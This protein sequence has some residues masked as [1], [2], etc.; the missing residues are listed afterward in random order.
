MKTYGKNFNWVWSS[1]GKVSEGGEGEKE[2][3]CSEDGQGIDEGGQGEHGWE[4]RTWERG[5]MGM[6]EGNMGMGKCHDP[7]DSNH[8][9]NLKTQ[10]HTAE[11]RPHTLPW[12]LRTSI[13]TEPLRSS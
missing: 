12:M 8:G 13:P 5:N 2:V 11:P 9:T 1:Y 3:G 4:K 6:E 10:R 7:D